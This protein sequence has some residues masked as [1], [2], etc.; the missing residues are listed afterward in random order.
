MKPAFP[1]PAIPEWL[2]VI[3]LGRTDWR[4]S[5]APIEMVDPGRLVG[6]VEKLPT[7]RF[8]LLWTV[9]PI[10]WGYTDT[11]SSALL[12]MAEGP[13]FAGATYDRDSTASTSLP[14]PFR[15]VR[16]R[17]QAPPFLAGRDVA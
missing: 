1:E 8:E 3:R 2:E 4:V 12:G 17:T 5:D 10:R 11:L 9:Y 7:G 14:S 13:G 16:R 15:R 6:F